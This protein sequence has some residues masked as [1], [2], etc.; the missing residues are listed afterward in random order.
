LDEHLIISKGTA[1]ATQ[2][3]YG[4]EYE[5]K[6]NSYF[7][8][9]NY[10]FGGKYL[11]SGTVRVDGSS[12]FGSNNRYGTFP[13]VSAGWVLTEEPIFS[14]SNIFNFLKLRASWGVNGN[15][16]IG[17]NRFVSLV[18]GGR[19]Y[20]IGNQDVLVNGVSPNAIAN[21]D[22][23]WEETTQ[24]DIGI[25]AVI[26][27]KFKVTLDYFY[28]ET[29]DMLLDIAVPGYVGNSGPVGNVATM[30]NQGFEFEFTY[31]DKVGEFNFDLAT[32]LSLNRNKVTFLGQDKEFLFG[33][34]FG[35]QGLEITRT[36]VGHPIGFLFG[37][38]TDGIF[39]NATEIANH[40]GKDGMLQ[41]DA[42]PG[43]FR[44]KDLNGDGVLDSDDREQIGDP[45]PSWTVGLNLNFEWRNFD[46]KVFGQGVVG[47]DIFKATRRFDLNMANLTT[48][49]LGRWTGEGSTDLY[50]RLTMNDANNNFSRSSDF[51][52]EDGSY[53]RIKTLQLG[54]TLPSLILS[55]VN[56]SNLRIYVSG[57]NLLTITDYSGFD[58]EI[59][60][61]SFGVDRGIYPQP[62]FFLLGLSASF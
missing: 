25:D 12:K 62:R 32:N 53:F 50:P 9:L 22:L 42:K 61:G 43:D 18:G 26:F 7:G 34:R 11:F 15:D 39:Q 35:P 5:N 56:M 46:L 60:G 24:T 48:D 19:N 13:S 44:F 33:Q 58:P 27:R 20:T 1:L 4:Y 37:Y 28:K 6:L 17:D 47:N 10:N 16:K 3:F 51:Y 41:P 55:K 2:S 40:T 38:R 45:T 49:A 21:P 30:E 52:V 59:G 29:T 57:N 54:Y 36:A 8:R 31:N 14:R 23:R